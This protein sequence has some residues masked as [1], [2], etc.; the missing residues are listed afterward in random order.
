MYVYCNA[1][2]DEISFTL[3][4]KLHYIYIYIHPPTFILKMAVKSRNM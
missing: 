3:M 4:Y 2:K 1:I